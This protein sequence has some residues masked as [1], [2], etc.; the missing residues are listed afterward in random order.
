MNQEG[1]PKLST[2]ACVDAPPKTEIAQGPHTAA[3]D[4]DIL[5][6]AKGG[7]IAFVGNMF[8]YVFRFG[9]GLVLARF[10]GAEMLGIYSLSLTVT[11]IVGAL[12]LLGLSTGMARYIP[13]G[14]SKKDEGHIWGTIQMG[15]AIPGLLS[16]IL[17]VVACLL[18]GLLST[19]VYR[20]PA[21]APVL[22]VA[23]LGIPMLALTDMLA[24]ITQGFK[25]MEYKVYTQDIALN[26]SKFVL[27]VVFIVAGLG[28]VG[29]VAAHVVSLA[30]AT[31]MLFYFVHRL[32]PLNRPWGTAK[33]NTREI[34]RFSVP[35]YMSNLLGQFSG[36]TETLILGFFGVMSRVGVYT[37]ALRL[38]GIGS[39]FH[40]SLQRIAMPMISDLYNR[41][42]L[43]Q[44]QRVY[45]TTTKWGMTF[46]LPIFMVTVIFAKPLLAIFGADFVAGAA[47]LVVLAFSTLFNASTGVCGSVVTMTGRSKLTLANSIIYVVSNLA[48]DLLLIRRWGIVGAAWAVTLCIVLLNTL[49]TVEVWVLLRLWP[50]DRSFLKP[51]AAIVVSSGITYLINVKWLVSSPTLLQL[52]IGALTLSGIYALVIV[53]LRLSPEDHLVL[54]RLWARVNSRGR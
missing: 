10:L 52:A 12:A 47:G 45:R 37:A 7:G 2:P 19:R 3:S 20:E 11:D 39:V 51:L 54:D 5:M 34:L 25:R 31:A 53:L 32:F 9:F 6:A 49:R 33:R 40:Q 22:R 16:L 21:L 30:I 29:A 50:Y 4:R 23:S 43:D 42:K 24:A 28:V 48:L 46:N 38:G 26:V 8:V 41:G 35:I 17:A 15:V 1:N 14:V 44:L 13:V 27:S 18:A 36:S